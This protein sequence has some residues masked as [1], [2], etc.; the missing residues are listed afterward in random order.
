ML[1]LPF[2]QTSGIDS[3]LLI[4]RSDLWCWEHLDEGDKVRVCWSFKISKW[5]SWQLLYRGLLS[6]STVD[7]KET[8]SR[9]TTDVTASCAFGNN[10]NSLKDPDSEFGRR[11]RV[12]FKFSVKKGLAMLFACFAHSINYIFRLGFVEDKINQYVRQCIWS[13][14]EYRWEKCFARIF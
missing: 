14:V 12:V 4:E 10:S 11:V 2:W 3:G 7:V 6:G 13:T 5:T 9:F 8:M 1:F